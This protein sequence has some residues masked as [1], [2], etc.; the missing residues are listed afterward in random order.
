MRIIT[1][2]IL[3]MIVFLF[4]NCSGFRYGYTMDKALNSYYIVKSDSTGFGNARMKHTMKFRKHSKLYNK[5]NELGKPDFLYEYRPNSKKL[6]IELFFIE[7]DSVFVFEEEEKY[8]K[9]TNLKETRR[10]DEYEKET[11]KRLLER[12]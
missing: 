8:S 6:V 1:N 3:L 9:W 12:N 7:M 10:L 4:A 2:F 5:I 11:Y